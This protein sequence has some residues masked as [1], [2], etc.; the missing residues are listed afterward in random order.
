[1][2]VVS[3][4]GTLAAMYM[5]VTVKQKAYGGKDEQTKGAESTTNNGDANEES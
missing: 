4:I 1:M 3:L 5:G 2:C